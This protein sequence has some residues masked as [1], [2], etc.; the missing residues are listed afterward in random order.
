MCT[1]LTALLLV[2]VTGSVNRAV[3]LIR[4]PLTSTEVAETPVWLRGRGKVFLLD[5]ILL[6]S[7]I[8]GTWML[9]TRAEF[10]PS[11]LILSLVTFYGRGYG[12]FLSLAVV[13]AVGMI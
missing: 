4:N 1:I 3:F 6:S 10:G 7:F 13:W 11:A 12:A 8:A 9:W 5:V 2:A